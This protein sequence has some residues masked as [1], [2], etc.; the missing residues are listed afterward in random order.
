MI[1]VIQ[2]NEANPSV[3]VDGAKSSVSVDVSKFG[4]QTLAVQLVLT[5]ASTPGSITATLQGS[6]DGTN[7]FD[8]GS[9]V[10]LTANGVVKLTATSVEYKFY[11][12]TYA[13]SS[14]SIVSTERF[15]VYG[16]TA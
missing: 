4:P 10:N 7:F 6:L 14:G 9:P 3:T 2:Y 12:V 1:K 5:A 11:R 13:R 8:V 15:M 16:A